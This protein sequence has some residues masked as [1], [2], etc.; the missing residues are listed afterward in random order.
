MAPIIAFNKRGTFGISSVGTP[1]VTATDV[2]FSFE[3]HPYVNAPFNGIL[4]VR[5]ST[6]IPTGTTGTLPVFFQTGTNTRRAVTKVGGVP[7]TAADIPS[8]GYYL[9][10][11]DSNAGILEVIS[12]VN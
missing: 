2:T 5:I 9:L 8:T 1:V 11:Y 12:A 10:F 4:L 7:L 6:A 3:S